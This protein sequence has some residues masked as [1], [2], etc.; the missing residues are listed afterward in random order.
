MILAQIC[1][2]TFTI[3]NVNHDSPLSL[4]GTIPF[5]GNTFMT[6]ESSFNSGPIE[7]IGC[8]LYFN[9][10]KKHIHYWIADLFSL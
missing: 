3:T 9:R 7:M 4:P 1:L 5:T 10:G 6:S 8:S 2:C